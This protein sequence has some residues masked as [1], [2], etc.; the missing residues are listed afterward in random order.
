MYLETKMPAP[1]KT[2]IPITSTP[3]KRGR[4]L[5]SKMPEFKITTIPMPIQVQA[6]RNAIALLA[7]SPKYSVPTATLYVTI[8]VLLAVCIQA[9]SA[10][11]LL[12]KHYNQLDKAH[13]QLV[14]AI[15]KNSSNYI[16]ETDSNGDNAVKE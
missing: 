14:E 10:V 9:I 1:E 11:T 3:K 8:A 5:K 13:N 6:E 4:P 7:N 16:Y 2:R 12:Q 15:N